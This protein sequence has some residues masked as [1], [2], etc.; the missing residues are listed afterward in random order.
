MTTYKP[1][2]T[3]WTEVNLDTGLTTCCS[4]PTSWHDDE[5]GNWIELCEACSEDVYG[6]IGE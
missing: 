3:T 5:M 6:Y 2:M 4:A 1:T